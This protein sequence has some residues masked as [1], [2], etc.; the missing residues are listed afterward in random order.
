MGLVKIGH[1]SELYVSLQS[2]ASVLLQFLSVL[3]AAAALVVSV[4]VKRTMQRLLTV[5]MKWSTNGRTPVPR[6]FGG[7]GV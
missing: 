1:W 7:E 4:D 2:I 6:L 3:R 5:I